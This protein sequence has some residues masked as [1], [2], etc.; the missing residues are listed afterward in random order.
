MITCVC[1]CHHWLKSAICTGCAEAHQQTAS[2]PA[3]S[4]EER[5]ERAWEND[6]SALGTDMRSYKAGYLARDKEK[7]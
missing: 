1:P 4:P 6:P 2:A 3:L 5:A 7:P